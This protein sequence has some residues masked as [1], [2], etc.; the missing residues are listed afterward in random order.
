MIINKNEIE[1]LCEKEIAY[2]T[3]RKNNLKDTNA[4]KS[5]K[6]AK[7]VAEMAKCVDENKRFDLRPIPENKIARNFEMFNLGDCV[8]LIVKSLYT[9]TKKLK[10]SRAKTFDTIIN[11][12]RYEVKAS[13]SASSK[14]T[15][16]DNE[17]NILFVNQKGVW[18]IDNTDGTYKGA[19]LGATVEIGE[20]AT[21]IAERL[22]F[23]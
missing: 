12:I 5:I 9:K 17:K 10:I 1:N 7:L 6:S 15:P 22:G 21:E 14:N 23:E 19:R 2:W 3:D 8:E 18:I 11:G 16:I 4:N 20:Y 13:M